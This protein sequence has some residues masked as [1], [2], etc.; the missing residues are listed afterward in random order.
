MLKLIVGTLAV[1]Q[2]RR[3]DIGRSKLALIKDDN[4]TRR[5]NVQDRIGTIAT[6]KRIC[7]VTRCAPERVIAQPASDI[8]LAI[9]AFKRIG[10]SRA[11]KPLDAV[12]HIARRLARVDRGRGQ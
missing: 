2:P 11:A 9:I 6:R 8:I 5:R 10:K 7:I 4:L 12:K 3:R 1:N